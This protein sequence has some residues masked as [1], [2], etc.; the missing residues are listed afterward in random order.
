[1]VSTCGWGKELPPQFRFSSLF[2]EQ[3]PVH[4]KSAEIG[5]EKNRV[6]QPTKHPTGTF[7]IKEVDHDRSIPERFKEMV[8]VQA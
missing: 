7:E 3:V 4:E 6:D 1:M 8:V 5:R 2:D